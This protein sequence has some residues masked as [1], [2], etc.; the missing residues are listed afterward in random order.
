MW[1]W[2]CVCVSWYRCQMLIQIIKLQIDEISF[3]SYYFNINE[4]SYWTFENT[5][6]LLSCILPWICM[7]YRMICRQTNCIELAKMRTCAYMSLFL[8][9][10][11]QQQ[12]QQQIAIIHQMHPMC[13]NPRNTKLL[14]LRLMRLPICDKFPVPKF[15]HYKTSMS[16]DQCQHFWY[17]VFMKLILIPSVFFWGGN[18]FNV[19]CVCKQVSL[20]LW[21]FKTMP[22]P[23]SNY[24]RF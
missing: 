2:V 21:K 20:G 13:S 6:C 4:H 22:V 19:K 8:I 15:K 1:M 7:R 23:I 12:Q 16:F 14:P 5:I 17:F 3:D 11:Q 18:L 10:Q 24:Y 9:F